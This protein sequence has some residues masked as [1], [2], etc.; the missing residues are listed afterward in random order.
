MEY[1]WKNDPAQYNPA[2]TEKSVQNC[3]GMEQ[4][5]FKLFKILLFIS[6]KIFGKY[7]IFCWLQIVL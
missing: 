1:F 5:G 4:V 2:Q 3:I 6:R 7:Q